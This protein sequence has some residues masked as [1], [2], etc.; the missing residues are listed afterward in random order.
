M[1]TMLTFGAWGSCAMSSFMESHLS[2]QKNTPKHIAGNDEFQSEN[3]VTF[4]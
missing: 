2:K 3:A 1:T 4:Y